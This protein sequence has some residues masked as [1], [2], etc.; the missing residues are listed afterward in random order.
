[1][2]TTG[3]KDELRGRLIESMVEERRKASTAKHE[4]T[5]PSSGESGATKTSTHDKKISPMKGVKRMSDVEMEDPAG[6]EN[7]SQSASAE[8]MEIDAVSE[9][10]MPPPQKIKQVATTSSIDNLIDSESKKMSPP[11]KVDSERPTNI[12]QPT[13]ATRST[14]RSP[15]R[16]MQVGV[17]STFKNRMQNTVQSALKNLRPVS[18]KKPSAEAQKSPLKPKK[19]IVVIPGAVSTDETESSSNAVSEAGH[20]LTGPTKTLEVPVP[21]GSRTLTTPGVPLGLSAASKMAN[22][23]VNSDSV[24]AKNDARMARIAEIRSKVC[25]NSII[26]SLGFHEIPSNKKNR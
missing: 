4:G 11:H 17:Q 20:A 23:T 16:R 19:Q 14:S 26:S 10:A 21:G 3:L 7:S 15:L 1:M 9:S 22:L 6:T 8:S 25:V 12:P 5:K 2:N 18:P 13:S 24:K